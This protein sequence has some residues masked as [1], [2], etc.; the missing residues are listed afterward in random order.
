MASKYR[1]PQFPDGK[2]WE[3]MTSAEK[4]TFIRAS[5]EYHHKSRYEWA[6]EFYDKTGPAWEELTE[7]Q[8]VNIREENDRYAREMQEFGE[9]LRINK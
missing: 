9:S 2:G 8:R 3:D 1:G 7:E 4:Q 6:L 5:S